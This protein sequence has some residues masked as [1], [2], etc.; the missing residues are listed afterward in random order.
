MAIAMAEHS[1]MARAQRRRWFSDRRDPFESVTRLGMRA[2]R[3][4]WILGCLVAVGS[5]G[6]LGVRAMM[7]PVQLRLWAE[8]AQLEVRDYLWSQYE[9]VI[10][11][12]AETPPP[13]EPPAP[14]PEQPPAPEVQAKPAPMRPAAPQEPAPAAGQAGKVLTAAPDPDEPVNLTD[15]G[16]VT[17]TG[18]SYTGGV[19]A[20][21]GTSTTPTYNRAASPT[22]VVG[23]KGTATAPPPPPPPV[24]NL[25]RTATISSGTNWS[26]CPFPSQA[27]IDQ[28]DYAQVTLVVTVRPDGSAQSVRV[29]ADPGHGFGAAARQCAMTKRY[30]PALDISGKPVSGATPPI[31]VTFTR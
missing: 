1:G 20:A 30:T 10:E 26:A 12:P 16:F 28:I 4:G 11:K 24:Q 8:Q 31:R 2:S 25:S 15:Q 19:T 5:H 14:E 21:T 22:G 18:D 29:L 6:V 7:S 13:P 17:G 27:D 9:V 3:I 23:G